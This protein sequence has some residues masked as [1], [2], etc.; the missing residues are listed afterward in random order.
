MCHS[1]GVGI[2]AITCLSRVNNVY[3]T[4]HT[5]LDL[6]CQSS[7]TSFRLKSKDLKSHTITI[8][9]ETDQSLFDVSVKVIIKNY[10]NTNN[11]F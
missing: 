10:N 7:N 3:F 4:Q 5:V 1:R 8:V 2:H 11:A 9:F 6:C